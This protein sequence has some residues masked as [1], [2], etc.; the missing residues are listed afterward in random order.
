MNKK[1]IFSAAATLC[2]VHC[3]LCITSCSSDDDLT[4]AYYS[5]PN[6]VHVNA[7]I[8]EP[9]TRVNT[10]GNGDEWQQYDEIHVENISSNAISGKTVT[11]FQAQSSGASPTWSPVSSTYAVWVDG[12][13]DFEAYYPYGASFTTFTLPTDQSTENNLRSADWMVATK[14]MAKPDDN[15]DAL[16]L[17]FEHQ[18]AKVTFNLNITGDEYKGDG[19]AITYTPTYVS[20][21]VGS[22]D[23][24]TSDGSLY[25]FETKGMKSLTFRSYDVIAKIAGSGSQYTATAILP[26]AK[27]KDGWL[28]KIYKEYGADK[29]YLQVD[30][31][32]SGDIHDLL[33]KT[34]LESG[35]SYTFDVNVGKDKLVIGK[36]EV[37]DW[38]TG[39]LE[40]STGIS[41][42]IA[43]VGD[44]FMKD[45]SY[46]SCKDKDGN[47]V[48]LTEEQKANCIGI[49][50]YVGKNANDKSS[51]PEALTT[52]H[53]YVI[54]LEDAN[55]GSTCK[56]SSS[57]D[58]IS[59]IIDCNSTDWSGY[60]NTQAILNKY[61]SATDIAAYYAKQ[62]EET[63]KAP[64]NTSGWFLP[65]IAQLK[66]ALNSSVESSIEKAGGSS[67]R[68]SLWASSESDTYGR[69]AYT[70][71][72]DDKKD[73][74]SS[75]CVR[76]VLAF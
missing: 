18:L 44:Y 14:T 30:I 65:G 74:G 57:K 47:A 67:S 68:Y 11:E 6:A 60:S 41:D 5:D 63:V 69:R 10:E 35:K 55:N 4:A 76:A 20:V 75:H 16:T 71:N 25:S 2:I 31:P 72:G 34:G 1:Y 51:Y 33:C 7:T 58:N 38:N 3:A 52:V 49:V 46:V 13:N 28:L 42:E 43:Q 37:K 66:E 29:E 62:Y 26:P 36:V 17:N 70:S 32:T 56:W 64:S 73:S 39:T 12:E 61:S 19:D 22:P 59:D 24:D 54:A 50:F 9:Q 23:G 21:N 27:Y 40:K 15:T 45:G 48:T 53:G 8:G